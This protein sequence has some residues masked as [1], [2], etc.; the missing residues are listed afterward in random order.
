A[1]LLPFQRSE[2][3]NA[4]LL[5]SLYRRLMTGLVA[6]NIDERDFYIAP[7][8]FEDEMK[9]GEFTLPQGYSLIPDVLLFKVVKGNEYI[10]A[11]NPEFNIRIS[12]KGNY[13]ID[14]IEYFVGSMLSRRA[15][16]EMQYGNVERAKVYLKKIHDDLP[17]Y[18][19]PPILQNILKEN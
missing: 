8:L 11:A 14:K 10:P 1:A 7:E 18:K 5:E 13:Y 12:D 19:I 17:A 6:A 9:R 4:T 2:N 15:M 16:Y 3:Y